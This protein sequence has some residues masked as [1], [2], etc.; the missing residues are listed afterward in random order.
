VPLFILAINLLRIISIPTS[1]TSWVMVAFGLAGISGSVIDYRN[2]CG[3]SAVTVGVNSAWLFG[4]WLTVSFSSQLSTNGF[5]LLICTVTVI[6]FIGNGIILTYTLSPF[7]G[8]RRTIGA[9]LLWFLVLTAGGLLLLF[10]DS[11]ILLA[12][13]TLPHFWLLARVT[14][15]TFAAA[16]L[17]E[18]TGIVL[19][20]VRALQDTSRT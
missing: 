6:G 1:A 15:V 17:A 2:G 14:G 16:L 18:L 3:I 8:R 7:S 9:S 10:L 4:Y 13:R 11:G 19:A 5:L 12:S 20:V